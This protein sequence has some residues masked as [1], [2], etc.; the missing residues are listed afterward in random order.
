MRVRPSC[1]PLPAWFS[2]VDPF[3]AYL[4]ASAVAG[5]LLVS[6]GALFMYF[7]GRWAAV[8]SEALARNTRDALYRRLHYL[9]ASFF[10]E[11]DT[12]DLVQRCSSDVETVRLFLSSH[13]VEIGRSLLMVAVMAPILFVR[14][15]ALATLAVCLMPL[16]A[17][18]AFVFFSRVRRQF[19]ITDE[20]EGA[21]T[22]VLQENL[23]ASAWCEP[24]RAK[25]MKSIGS[26]R[27]TVRFETTCT[28][29]TRW[30]RCIGASATAFP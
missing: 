15:T 21:M 29:S 24:S 25:P 26:P 6:I 12:G 16:L 23:A 1:W 14:D 17:I 22:A 8:A 11:A 10:D 5:V 4:L 20:A 3:L 19:Q 30:K 13:V 28:A 18:G 2:F 27:R 7:R 9:P